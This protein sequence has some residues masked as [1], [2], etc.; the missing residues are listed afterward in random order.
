MTKGRAN[1]KSKSRKKPGGTS[2]WSRPFRFIALPLV[3]RLILLILIVALLF[4]Q[5][6]AVTSWAINIADKAWE[7]FGWGLILIAI[8]VIII[9]GMLWRRQ[10]STLA[11]RWKLY[12]WNKWLGAVTFILAIWG[13]LALF[14]WGGSVG[15]NF[16]GQDD[17]TA[18]LWI[19]GLVSYPDWAGS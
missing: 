19:L 13:I 2:S 7:L 16:I 18:I 14:N 1:I 15:L 5:W 11:N 10:L 12:H 9:I 4:W 6:S 3:W 8:V 17:F